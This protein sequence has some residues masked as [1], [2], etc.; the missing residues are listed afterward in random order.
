MRNTESD[1][2][3]IRR[4]AMVLVEQCVRNSTLENLHAGI[5]PD[6]LTGDHSDVKVVTP[7]GE[8]SWSAL[9]RI[10]DDEMKLL[11]VEIVNKVYTFLIH[12]DDL[13]AL[14]PNRKW[15][16]PEIDGPLLSLALRTAEVHKQSGSSA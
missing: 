1:D 7:Y 3:A 14:T 13:A 16:Q 2:P 9:P 5:I 12:S 4:L 10:S 15:Q 6:S 8:I 11:I